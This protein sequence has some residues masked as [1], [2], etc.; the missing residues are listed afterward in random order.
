MYVEA[1]I[2][3]RERLLRGLPSEAL[4]QGD[5]L[6]Y[7]LV[8]KSENDNQIV[9]EKVTVDVG[10][11]HEDW[12]EVKNSAQLELAGQQILVKGIFNLQ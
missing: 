12:F 5:G 4:L 2:K 3:T 8:K 11:K 7:V 10:E 1:R 6:D 9:L